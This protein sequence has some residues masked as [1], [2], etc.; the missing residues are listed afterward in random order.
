MGFCHGT[1]RKERRPIG[2]QG[3]VSAPSTAKD[4]MMS[5]WM[6]GA[7]MACVALL[8]LGFAILIFQLDASVEDEL[9]LSDEDRHWT[10]II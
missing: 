2:F 9:R 3:L 5:Y 8:G 4:G 6:I 1:S 7:G 10:S